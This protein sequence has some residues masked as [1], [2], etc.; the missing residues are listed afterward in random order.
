MKT[1]IL[2]D[3]STKKLE[4]NLT[5][6]NDIIRLITAFLTNYPVYIKLKQT[7]VLFQLV[8]FMKFYGKST[9]ELC[10]KLLYTQCKLNNRL[11]LNK[12]LEQCKNKIVVPKWIVTRIYKSKIKCNPKVQK[13]FLKSEKKTG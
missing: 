11:I 12:Y 3:L 10:D 13:I 7:I 6:K 5:L 9:V 8:Y 4:Q 1:L 2:N